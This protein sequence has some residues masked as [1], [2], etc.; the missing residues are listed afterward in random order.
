M[1]EKTIQEIKK[2]LVETVIG[3]ITSPK[4]VRTDS[5]EVEQ[6]DIEKQRKA[7]EWAISKLDD[8]DAAENGKPRGIILGQ[9]RNVD[10]F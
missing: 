2:E 8:L 4:S 5:G 6:H 10:H 3:D 1:A 9:I 7:V